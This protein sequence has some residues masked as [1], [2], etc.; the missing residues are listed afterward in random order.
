MKPST[1][2]CLQLLREAGA[3]GATTHD[4]WQAGCGSRYSARIME[5]RARGAIIETTRIRQG[6]SRYVLTQD[7]DIEREAGSGMTPPSSPTSLPLGAESERYSTQPLSV[8]LSHDPGDAQGQL[9]ERPAPT[10]DELV[11]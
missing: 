11:A 5:L 3:E 6:C 10:F 4:F 8:A 2:K 7:I 1:T 9:F